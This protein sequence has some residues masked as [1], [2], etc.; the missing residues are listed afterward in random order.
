MISR[1]GFNAEVVHVLAVVQFLHTSTSSPIQ[2][3]VDSPVI[4]TTLLVKVILGISNIGDIY[5]NSPIVSQV[6]I[7]AV[8]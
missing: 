4:R 3:R 1:D 7:L 5:A 6:P 8:F 2:R